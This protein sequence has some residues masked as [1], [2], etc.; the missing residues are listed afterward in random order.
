MGEGRRLK[1]EGQSRVVE[2]LVVCF[3]CAGTTNSVARSMNINIAFFVRA[4]IHSPPSFLPMYLYSLSSTRCKHSS[5]LW[6]LFRRVFPIPNHPRIGPAPKLSPQKT[7]ETRMSRLVKGNDDV[8]YTGFGGYLT[9]T[10]HL[11][12]LGTQCLDIIDLGHS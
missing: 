5:N 9:T 12:G 6:I 3:G 4:T 10:I 1:V 11:R 2:P 7:T 8:L